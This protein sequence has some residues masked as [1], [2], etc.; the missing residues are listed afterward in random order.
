MKKER[1]IG[2]KSEAPKNTIYVRWLGAYRGREFTLADSVAFEL[3][4]DNWGIECAVNAIN[5]SLE[6]SYVYTEDMEEHV[7]S[8][9]RCDNTVVRKGSFLGLL[10]NPKAIRRVYDSDVW[11]EQNGP[12]LHPTR[13]GSANTAAE[14]FACR[15]AQWVKGLVV[16]DKALFNAVTPEEIQWRNRMFKQ[17]I[18]TAHW[19]AAKYGL[20]IYR[21]MKDGTLIKI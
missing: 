2:K 7:L 21:L 18:K 15:R 4:S 10:I 16:K 9:R 13:W 17:A 8:E 12:Y 6:L 19:C 3:A 1:M 5:T 20:S 14:A 11:S